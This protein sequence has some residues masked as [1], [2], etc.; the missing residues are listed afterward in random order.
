M[1]QHP[2]NKLAKLKAVSS[3]SSNEEWEFI[4]ALNS[5]IFTSRTAWKTHCTLQA[6]LK[7]RT[8][9]CQKQRARRNNIQI[10]KCKTREQIGNRSNY[11]AYF[12]ILRDS[13]RTYNSPSWCPH[14]QFNLRCLPATQHTTRDQ[15]DDELGVA[16]S[17]C[18]SNTFILF[19]FFF[20]FFFLFLGVP[21]VS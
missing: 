12:S 3:H 13:Q 1:S 17:N 2:T 7:H 6:T 5:F 19:F 9:D 21:D 20:F 16:S 15:L 11:C 18:Y 14:Q 4:A 10:S 8:S